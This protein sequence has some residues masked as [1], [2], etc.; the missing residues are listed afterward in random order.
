MAEIKNG[1]AAMESKPRRVPPPRNPRRVPVI[2]GPPTTPEATPV[3]APAAAAVTKPS[4]HR[5]AMVYLDEP[6]D[7]LL[8]EV[9]AAKPRTGAGG[10]TK[11]SVIRLAMARLADQMTPTEIIRTLA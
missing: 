2:P 1:L 10:V 9:L 5:A 3:T 6:S 7:D 4:V 8:R 11:S